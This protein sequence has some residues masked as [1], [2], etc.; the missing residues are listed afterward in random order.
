MED[1]DDNVCST[2]FDPLFI[3]EEDGEQE[4]AFVGQR[5]DSNITQPGLLLTA[6]QLN[7]SVRIQP[8]LQEMD[9]LLKSCEELTG[10]PLCSYSSPTYTETCLREST[11][12]QLK[13][14]V[15]MDRYRETRRSPDSYIATNYIDT[16]VDMAGT[17]D[18]LVQTCQQ[19]TGSIINR[20][21]GTAGVR[22]RAEMP[23]TSMGGKLSE[24][25]LQYE[26]HLLRMLTMMDS[27]MEEDGMDFDPQDWAMDAS[28]EYVHISKKQGT[29]PGPIPTGKM[30]PVPLESWVGQH[31][32]KDIEEGSKSS[33]YGVMVGSDLQNP[34]INSEN[35]VGI[36]EERL[37][38]L[39]NA[40]GFLGTFEENHLMLSASSVPAADV[41]GIDTNNIGLP[42]EEMLERKMDVI[43]LRSGLNE[44]GALG[45]QLEERIE[46]VASLEKKRKELL[47]EVLE[48]RGHAEREEGEGRNEEEEET[49]E[50][51]ARKVGELMEALRREAEV[52]GEERLKE[53][54]SLREQRAEEE[55]KIWKVNLE[56]QGL[57]DEIRRL[58]RRLFAMAMDCAHRQAALNTQRREVEMLKREEEKLQSL[59]L[60]LTE[61]GTQLRVAHKQQLCDLKA[62]LQLHT[63]SHVSNTQEE[64]TECRRHSCGDIQQ[65]LQGGLQVLEDRY[66]PVLMALLKRR[67]STAGSVVKA[68]EQAQDLRAQLGPLRE[69][70]QRLRLQRACLEE[71]LKL[72]HIHRRE[73]VE[74]YKETVYCLE[75]NSREL[76]TELRFQKRKT[77]EME[78]LK[79][80]LTKQ[81]LIYR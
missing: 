14:E 15:T 60:Q 5:A 26:G 8:Y 37:E 47:A 16:R 80:D 53:A 68:R 58:K 62:E 78:E 41:A 10:I 32:E 11:H 65:Y 43:D 52:R 17:E 34:L 63:S 33:R 75:E 22:H 21:P 69:E 6:T 76:K 9:E 4:R 23:L 56:R 55:R 70:I 38:N 24:S 51:T 81:L 12:N 19:D 40:N 2:G 77:K 61:E 28:Q 25:M 73:D 72:I 39:G 59:E 30:Q 71:K 74:K 64:L 35:T 3:L 42:P 57:Q 54:Q 49:E 18:Q 45:S 79:D 48:L 44:L 50:I 36:S 29:T 20:C 1:L 27:C 66:E 31:A 7:Q 46:E 13:E 67:E